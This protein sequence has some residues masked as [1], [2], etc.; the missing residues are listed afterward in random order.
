MSPE[1][2]TP[3]L[4]WIKRNLPET[5][6][7]AGQ[8]FDLADFL[9][10]R[11]SGS[12]ARSQCT[13][14]C[15]WTYL[16]HERQGWQQDFF[17]AVGISD[18]LSRGDM[19]ERASPVGADLG[20]L[21]PEAAAALGLTTDCRVGAGLIDAYA[22]ALGALAGFAGDL[23]DDRSP[24]RADCRDVELRHGDVDRAAAVR[25]RLGSVFRRRAAWPLAVRRRPVGDRR[26]ARPP[27]PLAWRGRRARRCHA[28]QDRRAGHAAARERRP[29]PCRAPAR[30]AGFP[31]QPLAAGRPACDRRG[32]RAD[33]GR[34]LR[35]PV[36]A[37]LAD[38]RRHRA[39]RP[40]HP[41][42]AERARL[43]HRHPARHRRPHPQS[44]ADGALFRRDRLRG[45]RTA[46]GRRRAARHGD[47]RG[48]RRRPLPGSGFSVPGDAAGRHRADARHRRAPALRPRLPD[49]SRDAPPAAANW[50]R[51]GNA[52][53]PASSAQG[54]DNS[55]SQ[56]SV[57]AWP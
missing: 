29:R 17:E 13:L 25:R 42:R 5:W 39:R 37:L 22:G 26:A 50:T 55:A 46:S 52:P 4:M 53:N 43:C 51:W 12:N 21:T 56:V 34:H 16:A 20:P 57:A 28:W 30:A 27:D 31:W 10:Y 18:M 48:C 44:L 45:G 33:A 19:P 7:R 47:G 40:P 1:M 49:L 35:Q 32:Q 36:Q 38:L 8:F 14:A 11:A 24:P 41:R 9:T 2:Q 23:A 54:S 6:A 3:K 15:K